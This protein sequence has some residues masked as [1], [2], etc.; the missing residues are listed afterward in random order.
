[1]GKKD[2]QL[3]FLPFRLLHLTL[4]PLKRIFDTVEF[5][6]DGLELRDQMDRIAGFRDNVFNTVLHLFEILHHF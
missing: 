5:L 3:V 6:F 2:D 4:L 1:M